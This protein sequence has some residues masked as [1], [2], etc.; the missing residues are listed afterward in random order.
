MGWGTPPISNSRRCGA[1]AGSAVTSARMGW[2]LLLVEPD[3]GF[4]EEIRGAFE[5]AGF[6]VQ[7]VSTGEEA[8]ERARLG[9]FSLVVLSAELPDMSGFSVCN[10]LKR[11]LP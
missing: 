8:V 6:A 1:F 2:N 11:A 3:A 10:R 7:I 9:P 4:A 5:P